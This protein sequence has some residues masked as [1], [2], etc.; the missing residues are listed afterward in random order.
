MDGHFVP[1]LTF[2]PIVVEAVKKCVSNPLDV[3]LMISN[4][5]KYISDY[6]D[7]GADILLSMQR[8]VLIW[9]LLL[10]RSEKGRYVAGVTVNP[11]KPVDLFI[12]LID[13]IDQVLIMTVYAGFAGQKFIQEMTGKIKSV[14]E[15]IPARG[16]STDLQV[17]G[18]INDSTAAICAD[19]VPICLLPE[20]I[21]SV[22]GLP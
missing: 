4:P 6:C 22:H 3:H 14:Y 13:K 19:T 18:G 9:N 8:H 21:F 1:N 10:M 15:T 16:L 7:A 5:E 2:G 12:D 11:D 20:A 17:D